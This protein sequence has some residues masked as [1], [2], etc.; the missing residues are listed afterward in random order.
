MAAL[1]KRLYTLAEYLELEKHSEERYAYVR[2]EVVAMSGAS[3]R[4]NRIV[5]NLL[6]AID[7][8]LEGKPC[9]VTPHGYAD[10]SPCSVALPLCRSRGRVR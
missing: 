9:E 4:H 8:R 7:T 3:L 5:R 6:R 10:Q 1:A 2:G